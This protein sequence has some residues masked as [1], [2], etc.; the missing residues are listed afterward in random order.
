MGCPCEIQLFA[1]DQTTAQ[2]IADIAIADVYRLEQRYSRYLKDNLMAQINQ[3]AAKGGSIEVDEETCSLLNYAETCYQ[4]SDGLFDI[5][6]GILRRVWRF[7]SQQLPEQEAINS[8]LTRVGWDKL[9]WQPPRLNFLT[10]DME[11]DFGGIVKEYAAD[12]AAALCAHAG[13][14]HGVVNLGGDVKIIGPRA[15]HRPWR[16]GIHHP[17]QDSI[18]TTLSLHQGAIA[19]SGDY[20]RCMLISGVRYSHVLNPKTGW[21]VS[22]LAA[23][24]VV[25][26]F[27]VVAGSASTVAMLKQQ[28]GPNWLSQLQL[29]HLWID[30]EG[31][32]GGSLYQ[33]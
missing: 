13:A 11:I 21:P 19:S 4:Q 30:T 16:I 10:A 31:R 2:A 14:K 15:D 23:V 12:R 29:P 28:Q 6:S 9:A 27:C 3:T 7:N 20:E 32:Q 26:D 5:T 8:L 22:F 1:H 33:E 18:A 24:T 17:R 25:S